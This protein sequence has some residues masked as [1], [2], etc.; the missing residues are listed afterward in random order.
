[1]ATNPSLQRFHN[2]QSATSHSQGRND[3]D[4]GS[5]FVHQAL[6]MAINGAFLPRDHQT[7][8]R[9]QAMRQT[10]ELL[11]SE[12]HQ[13]SVQE[14]SRALNDLYHAGSMLKEDPVMIDN[15]LAEFEHEVEQ[16]RYPIYEQALKQDRSYVEDPAFR[17]KFLRAN[18][19]DVK[20]AVNQ[21]INFLSHKAKYFGNN[22][23]AADITL[24]DLTP[25]ELQ[26]MLSGIYHIQD[27]T[28]KNGRLIVY[29]FNKPIPVNLHAESMVRPFVLL[30]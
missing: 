22:K 5:S 25:E 15:L 21:M 16:G 29:R 9:S 7:S 27:E 30:C 19:H 8:E 3:Y 14:Q 18:M 4:D 26:L 24:D 20:K 13:L 10:E 28:D 23:I 1:M 2:L 12:F 17:L 6:R 11:T